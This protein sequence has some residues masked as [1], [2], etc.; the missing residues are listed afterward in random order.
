MAVIT[1][2]VTEGQGRGKP[3]PER[4]ASLR[5]CYSYFM[6]E[7]RTFKSPTLIRKKRE[8]RPFQDRHS[9]K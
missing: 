4:L 7:A 8:V 6:I 9:R 5:A 1:R 3:R 2:D